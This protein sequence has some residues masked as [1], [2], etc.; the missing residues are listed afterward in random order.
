MA[1]AAA[2]SVCESLVAMRPI[3]AQVQREGVPGAASPM[4]RGSGS[5]RP[6]RPYAM[7]SMAR[8]GAASSGVADPWR[9]G[10]IRG[11]ISAP[12]S[13][14]AHPATSRRWYPRNPQSTEMQAAAMAAPTSMCDD[15]WIVPQT[16]SAGEV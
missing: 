3:M 15:N 10:T 7:R 6:E 11:T 1:G 14:T 2:S 9:S 12:E 13:S 8:L 16:D 4:R 5:L